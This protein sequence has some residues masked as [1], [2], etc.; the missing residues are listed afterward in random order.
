MS[1]YAPWLITPVLMLGGTYLC[2]EGAEK[3]HPW[4]VHKPKQS[5]PTE[6]LSHLRLSKVDLLALE[7]KKN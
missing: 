2:F 7:S 6:R 5:S 4:L 1:L 3:L